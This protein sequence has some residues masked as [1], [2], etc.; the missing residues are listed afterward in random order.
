MDIHEEPD[1]AGNRR[2]LAVSGRAASP[3]LASPQLSN[4]SPEQIAIITN[5]ELLA[6]HQDEKIGAPA[7]VLGKNTTDPPEF[8]AGQSS[9]GTHVFV[10]NTS[11]ATSTKS[12]AFARVHGLQKA[13]SY[14]VH[15]MWTGKDVGSFDAGYSFNVSAHDTAA[16]LIIPS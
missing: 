8:Y 6:F 5:R 15:D 13:S 11:N 12:F 1:S 9:K 7:T 3:N 14:I 4:L 10:I 16:Y 2:E